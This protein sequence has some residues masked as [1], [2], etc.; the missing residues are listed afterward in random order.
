MKWSTSYF[1]LQ[2]QY[3]VIPSNSNTFSDWR[4]TR[5]VSWVKT[6]LTQGEHQLPWEIRLARDQIVLLE[7]A[8]NLWASRRKANGFFVVFASFE[9]VGITKRLMMVPWETVSF[10]SPWPQCLR[11]SGKKNSL[12]PLGPV[13]KCLLL[14]SWR[15]SR[16]RASFHWLVHGHMTSNNESVSRQ[17]PWAR[18]IAK[19]MTSNGKQ[20]TVTQSTVHCWPLLHVMAG[21]SAR[22]SNFAFVLFCYITNHLM[23]GPL[24]NSEFCFPRI[25]MFPSTSSWETLRFSGNKIHSSPRDQSLSVKCCSSR[26]C[27]VLIWFIVSR[28]I[29]TKPLIK[30]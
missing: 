29:S 5:Y 30:C 28:Y 21:I 17:M 11:V 3:I 15:F 19:T 18:N 2:Y 26:H 4:R 16:Y 9:L 1:P 25:S 14:Y 24:G 20:F 12:F 22:F 13:I 8:A 23:T 10:V 27:T 6:P 7:I